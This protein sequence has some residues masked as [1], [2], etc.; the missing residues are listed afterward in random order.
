MIDLFGLRKQNQEQEPQEPEPGTQEPAPV[1]KPRAPRGSHRLWAGL[2]V[3]DAIFVIIFAGAVA[4]KIYQHWKSPTAAVVATA[5]RRPVKEPAKP[6]DAPAPSTAAAEVA[7]PPPPLPAPPAPIAAAPKAL[8]PKS[9][10]VP[11]PPKPSLLSDAPR[12]R[13]TPKLAGSAGAPAS[14][15]ASA[16]P[17]AADG[18]TKAVR[19]EFKLH[20][21]KAK[22]VYL[23]D[24]FIV[25]GGRR[26]MSRQSD[27]T[28][29]LNLYLNPGQ[30]R[31]FFSVDKKKQLDPENPHSERDA[32]VLS[33]P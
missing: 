31:Y 7:P 32:S 8:E 4:A 17:A 9:S 29:T 11:R 19:V 15:P 10:D 27:G 20:A 25:R 33:V 5:R 30:Y 21:P 2:L 14:A 13:E 24:A 3:I 6:A 23:V 18:K 1:A 26:E 12:H 22:E 16:L 28:W